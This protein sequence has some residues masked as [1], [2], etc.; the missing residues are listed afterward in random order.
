M[1]TP[2]DPITAFRDAGRGRYA[3]SRLI[4]ERR[5]ERWED[6]TCDRNTGNQIVTLNKLLA[7]VTADNLHREVDSGPAVGIEAW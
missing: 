6:N 7:Q 3:V 2:K 4:N 5:A 1:G